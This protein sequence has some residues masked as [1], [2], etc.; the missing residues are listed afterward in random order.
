MKRNTKRLPALLLAILLCL[1]LLPG[2]ALAVPGEPTEIQNITLEIDRPTASGTPDDDVQAGLSDNFSVDSYNGCTW[3]QVSGPGETKVIK[4]L[5][6]GDTFAN[7]SWYLVELP[8]IAGYRYQFTENT[9]VTVSGAKQTAI[10]PS[11]GGEKAWAYVWFR[12]GGEPSQTGTISSIAITGVPI[13]TAGQTAG[14]AYGTNL[15]AIDLP[16]GIGDYQYDYGIW[17]DTG[18][19]DSSWKSLWVNDEFSTEETYRVVLDLYAAD[20]Y[21]FADSISNVTVNEQKAY[22]LDQGKGYAQVMLMFTPGGTGDQ[23]TYPE[24][25]EISYAEVISAVWPVRGMTIPKDQRNFTVS[26]EYYTLT[27]AKWQR[28]IGTGAGSWNDLTGDHQADRI[29]LQT[30]YRIYAEVS[31]KE[32]WARFGATVTESINGTAGTYG[33]VEDDGET[34]VLTRE[35]AV[36]DAVYAYPDGD[37]SGE[38]DYTG[39]PLSINTPGAGAQVVLPKFGKT[40]QWERVSGLYSYATWYE[41][42]RVGSTYTLKRLTAVSPSEGTGGDHF[43][44]GKVYRLQVQFRSER[45][46]SGGELITFRE[47]FGVQG[48]YD[49]TTGEEIIPD[50]TEQT[51]ND[52]HEK[53]YNFWF[54]TGDAEA[55]KVTEV[56][57]NGPPLN[58]PKDLEGLVYDYDSYKFLT[59]DA[60][61]QFSC[62]QL[63]ATFG[64]AYKNEDGSWIVSLTLEVNSGYYLGLQ[65]NISATYN[66]DAVPFQVDSWDPYDA[67]YITITLF[68]GNPVSVQK[69]G[70]TNTTEYDTLEAAVSALG[71]DKGTITLRRSYT[72]EKDAAAITVPGTATLVI[73]DGMTLTVP[74][75][76]TLELANPAFL[77]S[78]GS[79]AVAAGGTLKIPDSETKMTAFV[80]AVNSA[81][82]HLTSGTLTFDM[83][84]DLLTLGAN[85]VAEIPE[86]QEAWLLQSTDGTTKT[87][88]DA[89]IETGAKLTVN[90]TL[91]AISGADQN[92]STL[93]VQGTLDA[94]G[95]TLS[96]AKY[97]KVAVEQGGKV[98]LSPASLLSGEILGKADIAVGGSVSVDNE[99]W[100]GTGGNVNLTAGRMTLDFGGIAS[101]TIAAALTENARAAVP[102]GNRWT[103]K[104]GKDTPSANVNLMV[105]TGSTLAVAGEFHVANN[106]T[107][108]V[109]GAVD[110]TGHLSIGSAGTVDGS[111]SITNSGVL[112]LDKGADGAVGNL[113]VNVALSGSGK[114]YAMKNIAD[115]LTNAEELEDKTYNEVEYA[116]AW[117]AE[118]IIEPVEPEQPITPVT[119]VVPSG[120]AGDDDDDGYSISV[121]ASSSIKG[122]SIT[123][124]PRSADKGDTVTIT[125]TPDEGYELDELTVATR[126][127]GELTL[128]SKGGGRYTFTM[129]ASDVKIQ[130][131]FREIAAPAVNPFIDVSA[132]AY[133]YDAVL[134]AVENGVTN[135]TT[136]TTFSP[137]A[138]VTRAQMVTFLWRAHGAPRAD[139]ANPFTDVSAGAYYYDAVLW[140][141]ASG[142]TNGTTATTFSPDAPV[143]RAQA[144]TFQWRAAGAPALSGESF[145]DV[146]ADAYYAGA[147][148][149]AV[150]NGITKGT[151]GNKFSP[152]VTVTRAQAVTFLWR[153]LA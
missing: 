30:R 46:Y 76:K 110:I 109:N 102:T 2:T 80:G 81:R 10:E 33:T 137:D 35:V 1:S 9:E 107:L 64:Y 139:G 43:E 84:E 134:W 101:G 85:A 19:K 6:E 122:G 88:L 72:L 135:G 77:D 61:E 36:Y 22:I 149:W 126:S 14:D 58:S 47:N 138:T 66:G 116:F 41:V 31:V 146:A 105:E 112:T 130:V 78:Q 153:E 60:L 57:V 114:A 18:S 13:P 141:V 100:I 129:P 73:P 98:T 136:A 21:T 23:T 151:G 117:T 93:T 48:F 79:I 55:Q 106:S 69:D 91:K 92:G 83:G 45:Y 132:G 40:P 32:P 38:P 53:T 111:G 124:S 12:V 140:A 51:V 119:P 8:L 11:E 95:G 133:Y 115:K 34:C 108:T 87:P 127:G 99:E 123:V 4:G 17:S 89:V 62:E 29:F 147:V 143:T 26:S 145:G 150:A 94:S 120:S 63:T 54:T 5:E 144:V 16:T 28:N 148:T 97:A 65:Q 3:Y 86:N 52:R 59:D 39:V 118:E 103:L 71:S 82:I 42:P 70:E 67:G 75:N 44:A 25:V 113:S 125:A 90:G 56:A 131:S 24:Y 104:V 15:D 142:I 128:T 74:D 50:L 96:V 152:E 37:T 27:V 7:N 20:D 68:A 121:P 49:L